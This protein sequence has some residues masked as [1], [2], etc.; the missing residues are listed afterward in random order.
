[1]AQDVALRIFPYS[2]RLTRARCDVRATH[3]TGRLYFCQSWARGPRLPLPP[4]CWVRWGGVRDLDL[5]RREKNPGDCLALVRNF[6][7]AENVLS[8]IR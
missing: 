7:R 2:P 3:G 6:F 8:Y 4:G 5:P 1:M